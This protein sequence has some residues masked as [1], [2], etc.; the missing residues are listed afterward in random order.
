MNSPSHI[1]ES[2]TLAG[3][4]NPRFATELIGHSQAWQTFL[5][6]IEMKKMHHAW[7]INGA[8]GIGKATFAWKIAENLLNKNNNLNYH[9]KVRAL[10]ISNLFLCRRPY[11]EKAKRL[12]QVITIDEIRKLKSFFSLSATENDW[13]IAIIDSAD[14]LN[15]SAAN[16]LLKI[17]EEPPQKSIFLIISHQP[18]TVPLTIRSRCRILNLNKLTGKEIERVLRSSDYNIKNLSKNDQHIL[19]VISEGSVGT[20]MTALNQDGIL[21]F[22]L[23]FEILLELPYFDRIKILK[24]AELVKGN[25]EKFRFFSF[26]LLLIISRIALLATPVNYI[27]GTEEEN[28]LIEKLSI[29]VNTANKLAKLYIDLSHAFLS[30][31][32]LNLDK[33]RQIVTA[34]T[35]I[36]KTI[37]GKNYEQ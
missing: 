12:K 6:S 21:I 26:I 35:D 15:K 32:A 8:K 9:K 33:S 19:A 25:N 27:I 36:E 31:Y 37:T 10:S 7:L 20:A 3:A 16:A 17:L 22:K 34:F 4:K 13:R 30:C 23:C 14:E 28:L 5:T 18:M 11:D 29:N 1:I 24:I 2:D